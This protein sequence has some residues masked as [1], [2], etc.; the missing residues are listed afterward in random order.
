[1]S[2]PAT[3]DKSSVTTD[4]DGEVAVTAVLTQDAHDETAS[5]PP[6]PAWHPLTRLAF[7]FSAAYLGLFCLWMAQITFVFFGVL[8]LQLPDKVVLWQI[9]ALAPLS[10]WIGEQVF[11]VPTELGMNGS[12]DQATIWIQCG[13]VLVLAVL[14]TVVWS[15]LDRRRQAYP[16]LLSWLLT[17]LRLAVG[18]QMLFY[19]FAKLVPTQMPEPALTTLLTQ[20]GDLTPMSMLWTQVGA[21]PIYQ[22]ALGAAEVVGGLLLFWPRTATLG[23]MVTV[24]SMAQ[25]FL[26]NM[27]YD[28]PVKMLSGHLLLM[29]LV[30]LAPQARRLA[31]VLVLQ[32]PSEPM[33]QPPLFASPR[34]NRWATVVQIAAAGWIVTGCLVLGADN[35]RE[36]GGGAPKPELYGIWEVGEFTVERTQLPPLS[37]DPTR[38][39][40]LIVDRGTAG[41]QRMDDTIVPVIAAV[42]GSTLTLT[43]AP[44]GPDMAP[45]P[46]ANFTL[47]RPTGDR[48]VLNG[49]LDGKPATVVL[50]RV[51]LDG[52]P[53]RSTGFRW[54]QNQPYF[55]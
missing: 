3:V 10:N 31:N 38:W 2:T 30:L 47:D 50:T 8:A 36:Y 32:R 33:T 41:Y 23:A 27:T 49:E 51:D 26:L 17:A 34:A 37:T 18:G 52:F 43:A 11:G 9:G 4:F 42:D 12:G 40:R 53:L 46:Y 1:M 48:L 6:A 35:W 15:V 28:V 14:I 21:S 54:V 45:A 25:V 19:G 29:S 22:M 20:V 5:P 24:I 7:R 13:L 44:T 39:Q 55:G 16:R